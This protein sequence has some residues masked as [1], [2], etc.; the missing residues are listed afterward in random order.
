MHQI[1]QE[2]YFITRVQ[3]PLQINVFGAFFIS[4]DLPAVITMTANGEETDDGVPIGK[5]MRRLEE[6]GADVVGLNCF[7]GPD[8]MLPL[9]RIVR[10]E[11]KVCI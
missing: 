10:K 11:C 6:L 3:N 8:T 7:R 9:I 5:A 1:C 4:S 2:R